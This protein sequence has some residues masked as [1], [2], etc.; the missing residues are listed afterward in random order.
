MTKRQKISKSAQST[1]E[2]GEFNTAKSQQK[3]RNQKKGGEFTYKT[4][5]VTNKIECCKKAGDLIL[6]YL[7]DQNRPYSSTDITTNL[8]NQMSKQNAIKSLETLAEQGDIISKTYGKLTYY[9]AKEGIVE[10]ESDNISTEMISGLRRE[11]EDS[12]KVLKE[13]EYGMYMPR[14]TDLARAKND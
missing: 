6:K 10:E 1:V 13:L 9:V 11:Y 8:H 14:S 2:E 7:I 3:E 5:Q 4:E 12:S